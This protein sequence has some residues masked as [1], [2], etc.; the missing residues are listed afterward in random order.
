MGAV[1]TADRPIPVRILIRLV[2]AV[3]AV[4]GLE[5]VGLGLYLTLRKP[6]LVDKLLGGPS[7]FDMKLIVARNG[8]LVLLAALLAVAGLAFAFRSSTPVEAPADDSASPPDQ[9]TGASSDEDGGFTFGDG[10]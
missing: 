5:V 1:A 6:Y 3:V 9:S 2:T 7:A 10:D 8:E 4:V